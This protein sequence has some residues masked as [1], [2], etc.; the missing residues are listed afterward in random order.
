KKPAGV[1][2]YLDEELRADVTKAISEGLCHCIIKKG[3]TQKVCFRKIKE[4]GR[5]GFHKTT[6][7]ELPEPKVEEEK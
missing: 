2:I 4:G 3:S 7:N 1:N 6:C 5:C